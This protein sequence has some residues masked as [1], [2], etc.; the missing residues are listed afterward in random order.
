[1]L[2]N[3]GLVCILPAVG[4]GQAAMT[5]VGTALGAGRTEDAREWARLTLVL[6]VMVMAVL[7]VGLALG[8]PVWLRVMIGDPSTAALGVTPLILLGLS[9]PVDSIG[10]VLSNT[11]IGAGAVRVVMMW[12]VLLQWGLCLPLVWMWVS[13]MNGG[14]VGIWG[15]FILWRTLFTLAMIALFKRDSWLQ[16]QV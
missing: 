4:F 14:L 3:L 7:G 11:L 6:C 2:I 1:V 12:S 9:Q 16:I 13:W 10:V 8:A 15:I 5:L